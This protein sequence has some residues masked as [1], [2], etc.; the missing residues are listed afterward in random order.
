MK[1]QGSGESTN[2]P[3]KSTKTRSNDPYGLINEKVKGYSKRDAEEA[4][5][6]NQW[7]HERLQFQEDERMRAAY[8]SPTLLQRAPVLHSNLQSY[9]SSRRMI[10]KKS[11]TSVYKS[12][13]EITDTSVPSAHTCHLKVL[14]E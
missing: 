13:Y 5:N 6:E 3:R 9:I 8:G 2:N 4:E 7:R 11:P 10:P 12:P 1:I 14:E